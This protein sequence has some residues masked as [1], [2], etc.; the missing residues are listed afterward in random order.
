MNQFVVIAVVVVAVYLLMSRM[1]A[2]G[3]AD[4]A[5]VWRKIK[6]GALVIDVRTDGEFR[7]GHLEGA[8][9][10]PYEQTEALVKAVGQDKS[11]SVIVYCRSGRRS[12]LAQRALQDQGYQHVINGGGYHSLKK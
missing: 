9:N 1:G 8:L 6:E 3:G 7:S 11:R 2:M 4:Q 12:G 10:I 5:E